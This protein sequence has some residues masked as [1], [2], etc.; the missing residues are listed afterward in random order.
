[1]L[2]LSLMGSWAPLHGQDQTFS[3]STD[4]VVPFGVPRSA[5]KI[6]VDAVLDEPAWAEAVQVSLDYETR[7]GENIPA[8]VETTC[9]VTHDDTHLYIAFRAHD[10]N[11]KAI[12]AHLS[13]RD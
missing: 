11:P 10:P 5:E 12:R 9:L 1:M 2:I 4:T 13:D 3:S 6:Q 8:P 7:P